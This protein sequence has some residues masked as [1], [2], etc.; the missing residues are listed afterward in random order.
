[1]TSQPQL[2]MNEKMQQSLAAAK[3]KAANMSGVASASVGGFCDSVALN[4][5]IAKARM[6]EELEKR[7]QAQQQANAPKCGS[8]NFF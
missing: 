1:M 4:A 2:T 7:R 6:E 5:Q 8:I 3:L